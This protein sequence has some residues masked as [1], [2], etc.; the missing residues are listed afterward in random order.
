MILKGH[1]Y[2]HYIHTYIQTD[3]QTDRQ[4]ER[5]TKG[6]FVEGNLFV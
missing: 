2:I 3:R 1:T 6:V 4:I 5:E